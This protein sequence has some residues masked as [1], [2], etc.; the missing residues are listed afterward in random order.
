MKLGAAT[1]LGLGAIGL[2][3]VLAL[4]A[5][6]SGSSTPS[7]TAGAAEADPAT[8]TDLVGAWVTEESYDSPDVPFLDFA[9]DGTWTG[10]DGCNGVEGEWAVAADGSLTVS[11][12]MSTLIACDGAALPKMLTGAVLALIDGDSLLLTDSDG[13]AV[14]TLVPAPEGTVPDAAG[15]V[16]GTWSSDAQQGAEVFLT[17]TDGKVTGKDGCNNLMGSWSAGAGGSIVLSGLASTMMYCEGVDTWLSKAVGLTLDGRTAVVVDDTGT[18][19][20]TLTRQG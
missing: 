12:G 17:F 13:A 5:C 14:V 16:I 19:I 7:S 15:S 6:A 9:D 4:S 3:V 11:A 8:A 2:A 1:N 20:G 10:S 18:S